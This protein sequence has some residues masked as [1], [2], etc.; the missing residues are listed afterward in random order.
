M[1]MGLTLYAYKKVHP[2]S[3]AAARNPRLQG[4]GGMAAESLK[5]VPPVDSGGRACITVRNTTET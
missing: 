3:A 4:R 1:Y 5:T 2:I